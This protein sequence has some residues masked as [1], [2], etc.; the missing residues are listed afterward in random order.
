MT[1]KEV[2]KYAY[3]MQIELQRLIY[4]EKAGAALREKLRSLLLES[5]SPAAEDGE[6]AFAPYEVSALVAAMKM[7]GLVR[8]G[9]AHATAHTSWEK[10]RHHHPEFAGRSD[11]ELLAAF[12]ASGQGISG[13]FGEL[14]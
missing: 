11:T 8:Y 6:A 7:E 3:A 4:E 14:F 13:T 2:R 5:E 9:L 1:D 12:E 10:V